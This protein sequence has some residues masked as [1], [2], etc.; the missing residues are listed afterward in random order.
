MAS[1]AH[2]PDGE[3]SSLPGSE[4]A[5]P[6]P[7]IH[8]A[9]RD[10]RPA[11]GLPAPLTP[12][13]GRERELAAVADLL[14]RDG[15]RLVTL[16]G[17]GGVGKTRLAF[18]VAADVGD[19]FADGVAFVALAAVGDPDLVLPTIA[20]ALGV[21]EAGDEPLAARVG[22]FL[23]D[24]RLLLVLDNFEQAVEAAPVVADL[25]AACPRVTV[26]A[27]SRVRLRVSG[28]RQYLVPPLGLVGR[29]GPASVE[30]AATS[31]AVRLFVE[32]AQGV[33]GDFALTAANAGAVAEVCRRLDGLPLAIELAAAW[34]RVLPPTALLGRLEKRLPLLTG[35]GRDLPA[36]QQTMRDAI[37]WSH[38]LLTPPEQALFRRLAVFA[39]GCTLEAAEAVTAAA[40]DLGLEVLGGIASLVEKSLLRAEDGPDGEP[41]YAMLETV[42]EY[43]LER[44]AASGEE[45]AV[46]DRHAR[47]FGDLAEREAA[48]WFAGD[49]V[50]TLDRVRTED[51]NVH[52]ALA[53]L[54]H[55]PDPE[56]F[57][58]LA[59]ELEILWFVRSQY[60]EGRHWLERALATGARAS[61]RARARARAAAGAL[62]MFQGDYSGAEAHFAAALALSAEAGDAV[63]VAITL[64]YHGLLAYRLGDDA[65]ARERIERAL[66]MF[67]AAAPVDAEARVHLIGALTD[68]GD[69]AYVMGDLADAAARYEE[70]AALERAGGFAW[71]LCETLP[72]L[73]HTRLARGEV[74]RAEALY[75]EALAIADRAGDAARIASALVGLA[76]IAAARGQA[77]LAARRL[78]AAEARTEAAAAP[79]YRRDRRVFDDALAASRA[80]LGEAGFEAARLAGRT[81]PLAAVGSGPDRPSTQTAPV[82]APVVAAGGAAEPTPR[83]LDVLRLLAGG[84]T[85]RQIADALFLSP[86]TVHH[87]V[88]NL[89]A[90][91][92][93]ANRVGAVEAARAAGLLPPDPP[94]RPRST[95]AAPPRPPARLDH[96]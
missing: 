86:R 21:R 75:R 81:Q 43:G 10:P 61:V 25:L 48:A 17:P 65:A 89:L 70:A 52:A 40:P 56:P 29:G 80:A 38:D 59:T 96:A 44:L 95:P 18:Q 49:Q 13:V 35:G 78:G 92:G 4:P 68:L 11:P 33:K 63:G 7:P 51:A 23:R 34:V 85:D 42:R 64:A 5:V 19:D 53:W 72:G 88:A 62:A 31:E 84:R 55:A 71:M 67:R 16:T 41:R 60:T 2:L 12:L 39:G 26:L 94:R 69:V 90:K 46:R 50:A 30:D 28:E 74:D 57:V 45:A 73:A 58:R 15:V 77:D 37:A 8:L 93:T 14:R 54:E 91:L 76:G 87:H 6:P 9:P 32:R 82:P 3:P 27:T 20:Q 79:L 22:A 47:F 1:P 83:E 66:G 36:R 24:Q